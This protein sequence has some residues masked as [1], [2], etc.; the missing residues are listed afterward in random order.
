GDGRNLTCLGI[1]LR[2]AQPVSGADA[3][4]PR[5]VQT[6]VIRQG[7]RELFGIPGKDQSSAGPTG[8]GNAS[9]CRDLFSR[10]VGGD[11]G[12]I[13]DAESAARLNRQSAVAVVRDLVIQDD[14]LTQE[15]ELLAGLQ[16]D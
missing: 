5:P 2:P 10:R 8:V 11:D 7:E 4:N 1:P 12:E 9:G 15:I 3:I 16:G 13:L 6:A 14:V